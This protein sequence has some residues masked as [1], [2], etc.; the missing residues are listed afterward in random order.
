MTDDRGHHRCFF[1]LKG[2]DYSQAEAYSV[3]IVTRDRA[4]LFGDVVNGE[5]RLNEMAK[6]VQWTWQDLPTM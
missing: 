5:M 6:I 2:R 4:C 1:R 3:T